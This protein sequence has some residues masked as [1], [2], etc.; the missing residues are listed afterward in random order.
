MQIMEQKSKLGQTATHIQSIIN[1]PLHHSEII[2]FKQLKDGELRADF[3]IHYKK[4]PYR[5]LSTSEKLRCMLDIIHLF[6]K[7]LQTTYPLFLDN[8]ES[9]T[10]LEPLDTQ[11]ITASVKKGMPLTLHVK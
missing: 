3:Q 11:I 5:I 8:L 6:Q 9:T 7:H 2:L 10:H 4:R 1:A